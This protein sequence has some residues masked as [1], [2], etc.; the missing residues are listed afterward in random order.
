MT[1]HP[2]VTQAGERPRAFVLGG[3]RRVGKAIVLALAKAGCDVD[4]SYGGSERDAQETAAAARTLGAV[5]NKWSLALDD[6]ASAAAGAG[7]IAASHTRWDAVVL[8]ASSYFPT[9]VEQLTPEQLVAAYSVNAASPAVV[10]QQFLSGLR[11][12]HLPG[13]G[14]VVT[15]CD[16]HAMGE[17]GLPRGGL[18]AY[19]MSKAAL[20]EMTLVL[21]KELAPAVRVNGVA[22]GVVAWPE[23]GPDADP[24]MQAKY[25]ARVPLGR[26]GTPQ[27]AAEAVRWLALDATYCTGHVI[28]LDGGRS[29]S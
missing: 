12:S 20:L 1:E 25:L 3:A 10:V 19:A 17:T 23:T 24:A 26:A 8:C 7:R 16:I 28:R 22:P 13:G 14:A 21:A 9:P 27:E 15:M 5:C 4:F 11:A 6:T 2:L 18:L 29:L